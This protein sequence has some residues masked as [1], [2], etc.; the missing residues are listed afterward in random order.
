RKGLLRGPTRARSTR[1][2]VPCGR[3]PYAVAVSPGRRLSDFS[4]SIPHPS[5][6]ETGVKLVDGAVA[7]DDLSLK[8]I[9]TSRPRSSS[10]LTQPRPQRPAHSYTRA[11]PAHGA[12]KCSTRGA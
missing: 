6:C 8:S 7:R 1:H 3:H 2:V 5:R 4:V 9:A 12:P 10:R 11:R